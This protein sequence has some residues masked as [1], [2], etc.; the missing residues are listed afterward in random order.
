MGY[1]YFF[2]LTFVL[3]T[4]LFSQELYFPPLVGD[5]WDTLS[6]A[7]LNWCEDK[8]SAFY[9]FLEEKNTKSFILLKNGKI[10]LEKYF[11]GFT[12]D[13]VWYW[14]SAG[15]S[16]TAVLAG[17]ARQEG[18]LDISD[19]VSEHLG[20]GWT[21]APPDKEALIT[22]R[23]QLTMTT[24]LDETV[25]FTCTDP[26]CLVYKAD[27]GTRWAYHN[28][29]YT[30]LTNVVEAASGM[31][32]N[33]FFFNK[34]SIKTGITGVWI[35]LADNRILFSKARSMTRFGLLL[36]NGGYWNDTPVMTDPDYIA[37]MINTSQ[38]HNK[39]YGYLWW[40]NGKES[41]MLPGTQLVFPGPLFPDA[42]PD[43]YAALGKNA[44][45][46]N[47]APSEGIVFVRMGENPDSSLVPVS[48]NNEIWQY[49][50]GLEC[51]PDAVDENTQKTVGIYPNPATGFLQIDLPDIYTD[52]EVSV[53]DIIG[54]RVIRRYNKKEL[55]V[56]TLLP[57]IYIIKIK[58]EEKEFTEILAIQ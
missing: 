36:L 23:H 33:Q 30:L 31:T 41:F 16:M 57:G 15:K 55:D 2:L 14:A 3:S 5:E 51:A 1:R 12:R 50:N 43:V 28:G 49:I 44:Q 38:P 37:E 48:F 7:S 24:G 54:Q 32:Y 56:S 8:I 53:F 25:N 58:S 19:S 18:L 21:S 35:P 34:I 17:I 6:P 4:R 26:A 45:Y 10:V 39:S 11:D 47:V 9:S 22:I 29:P 40:L 42:P 52:Y 20:T 27:A 46:L 13:S